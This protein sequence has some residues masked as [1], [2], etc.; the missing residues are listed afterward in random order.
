M[1]MPLTSVSVYSSGNSSDGSSTNCTGAYCGGNSSV[2]AGDSRP[3]RHT[4]AAAASVIWRATAATFA[5]SPPCATHLNT[6]GDQT[7]ENTL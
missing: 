1:P 5:V 2:T 6:M 7:V 4:I 3:A